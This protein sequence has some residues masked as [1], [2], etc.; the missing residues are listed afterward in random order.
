MFLKLIVYS[1]NEMTIMKKKEYIDKLFSSENGN[2]FKKGILTKFNNAVGFKDVSETLEV[3]H[4][5]IPAKIER[6]EKRNPLL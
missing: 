1:K 5:I 2:I 3:G 6:N 4:I